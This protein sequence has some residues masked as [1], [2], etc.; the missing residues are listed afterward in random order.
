M[1]SIPGATISALT[2]AQC[3]DVLSWVSRGAEQPAGSGE[4]V[5][6]LAH[7]DDGVIWGHRRTPDQSWAL[8]SHVFPELGASL[9]PERLQEMRVFGPRE[10]WLI[11]RGETTLLGRRLADQAQPGG[12]QSCEPL[13]DT[14]VLIGDRWQGSREGFTLVADGAGSRQA[15]PLECPR[16]AF[17][18]SGKSGAERAAWPLRLH[19]CHYLNSDTVTGAVR[20][21]ASRLVDVTCPGKAP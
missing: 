11:W 9:I 12:C 8:S 2:P 15:V 16:G 5:W 4:P 3:F 13:S 20:V 18:G 10:E 17:E 1:S 21:A 19:L 6:L 7:C 14:R